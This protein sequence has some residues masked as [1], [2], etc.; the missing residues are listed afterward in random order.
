VRFVSYAQNFEDVILWRALKHIE[1]GFYIDVGANHPSID[2]VT[3]A[4]YERGW[5]G[6]NI[7]P[8]PSHHAELL[9]DRPRDINLLCAAGASNGEIEV[10]E[11]DVRG[12][13]TA[14]ADVM[15]QHTASGHKG[16][17]HKVPVSRLADICSQHVS[18]EIHFLKIDVEGFEK[19]VID[20]AD[21]SRFRPWILVIEATKP[22]STEE[23]HGEWE[24][25]VLSADY[26]LGY[27]D[28]LNRFYI[29]RER[30]ELRDSLRHPPNVFDEFIRSEQLDSELRAQQAET[31]AQ[32]AEAKAL[33]AEAKALQAEAKA[34][35]AE[36]KALQA[37][38]KAQRAEAASFERLAQL[39]AVY[40]STSW[41]LTK[42]IRAFKRILGGDFS[43]LGRTAAAVTLKAKQVLRAAIANGIGYVLNQPKLRSVLIPVFKTFPWLL[44]RLFRVMHN[45]GVVLGQ[46]AY[47]TFASFS[48]AHLDAA[49]LPQ[50]MTPRARRIYVSLKAAVD[51]K[52]RENR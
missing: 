42:P 43:I 6:I 48:L 32:Q 17:F 46:E 24:S 28:G 2:S 47:A 4:F 30:D 9:R 19:S 8:L 20:G 26:V 36:A 15:A 7:E 51:K 25:T 3:R 31:R 21:F 37:E 13:A 34:L 12:W 52:N 5:H 11:C 38:A 44:P 14:S 39:Q 49:L 22:N 45:T 1:N 33:Q 50:T 27:T 35:Q 16:I 41:R 18:G 23:I 29:A 10:W 40:A